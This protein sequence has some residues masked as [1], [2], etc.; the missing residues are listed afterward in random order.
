[1]ARTFG[2]RVLVC[3]PA[4]CR[5]QRA[6]D[7][8]VEFRPLGALLA[9]SDVVSLHAPLSSVTK[10]LIGQREIKAMR[11]GSYLINTAWAGLVDQSAL[12]DALRDGHLAGAA[13]DDIDYDDRLTTAPRVLLTRTIVPVASRARASVKSPDAGTRSRSSVG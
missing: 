6:D 2:M 3:A 13:R 1:M 9:E 4:P 8:G 10:G 7:L 5:G 12:A 11:A